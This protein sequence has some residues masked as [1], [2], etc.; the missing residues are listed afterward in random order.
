MGVEPIPR[1]L[2]S[3]SW[4][5]ILSMTIA[6]L[7]NMVDSMYV[8]RISDTAD[9]LTAVSYAM[10][11]QLFVISVAVG[12]GVGANSLISRRLGA[13]R[14]DEANEA[15]NTSI[16]LA[17]LSWILFL[18]VGLFLS[19]PFLALYTKDETIFNY[20]VDYLSVVMTLSIF[21][22]IEVDLEKLFQSTGNMVAPMVMSITGC[23]ANILIDPLFIFGMFGFPRLEVKGAAIATVIGQA[24]SLAVGIFI[25]MKWPTTF[26]LKLRG[27]KLKWNVIRDIYEVA[28]PAIVM[29]SIGS[30]MLILYNGIITASSM[31]VAVLGVY[32]KIESFVFMP[33]FGLQQG[34]L[35]L[36]GFNYGA[37]N[38]E[39]LMETLKVDMLA[40][41]I[42]MIFGTALFQL[43]PE[44]LLGLF[45][46][47][48]EMLKVGVP[49]L[50]EIS[51]CFVP[52]AFGVAL[53]TFFQAVGKGIYSLNASF[54]R[55][56]IGVL[57]LAYLFCRL[58]GPDN[59]WASFPIAEFLGLIYMTVS[60]IMFYKKQLVDFDKV[61]TCD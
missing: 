8:S 4:P 39:R 38:K 50:R 12:T 43:A 20:G 15:A 36:M 17:F 30:V 29:Q 35:P 52:A 31:A 42:I 26:K 41:G 3:M 40:S 46:A 7:Y 27:M 13:K 25:Y 45:N 28:L 9:A 32:C 53:E 2:L 37:R 16:Y 22:L 61:E 23:I 14:Y 60:F 10:P 19:K 59:T 51:M 6:A 49:A 5:A 21:S 57:P 24:I 48:S 44:W 55:Q 11:V 56:F 47:N 33:L 34:A 18:F 54:I 1:L 58:Y